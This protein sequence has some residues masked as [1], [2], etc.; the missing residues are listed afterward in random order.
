[1]AGRTEEEIREKQAH[2]RRRGGGRRAQPGCDRLRHARRRRGFEATQKTALNLGWNQPFY[3]YNENTSNGNATANANIKYLMNSGFSY[4]DSSSELKQDK[5]FGTYEKT[6]DDPLTVK[7]TV[8]DD[9]KWSDGTPVDAADMLLV[10]AS[11]AA[12]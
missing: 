8:G 5:S 2:V 3:S 12:T 11:G 9:T 4:Y 10:W 6:S 1:M 7:Y